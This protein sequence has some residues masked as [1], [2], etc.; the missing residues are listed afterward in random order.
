MV[1]LLDHFI[2]STKNRMMK[3]AETLQEESGVS[4]FV[5]TILLIV[6]AVAFGAL[7]WSAIKQW[8]TND[9]WPKITSNASK[10]TD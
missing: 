5:A 4:S 8:F 2:I 6:I 9:I 10:I 3:A 7:F 1:Q